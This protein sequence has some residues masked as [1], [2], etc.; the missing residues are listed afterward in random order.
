M[1]S[2]RDG[3]FGRSKKPGKRCIRVPTFSTRGLYRNVHHQSSHQLNCRCQVIAS[4]RAMHADVPGNMYVGMDLRSRQPVVLSPANKVL[5]V[6]NVPQRCRL[7]NEAVF[8]EL[9]FCRPVA[10]QVS[11]EDGV[12]VITKELSFRIRRS[13]LLSGFVIFLSITFGEGCELRTCRDQRTNWRNPIVLLP[14]AQTY[15][16]L[17]VRTCIL[18]DG[19]ITDHGLWTSK[20]GMCWS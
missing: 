15:V 13:G 3:H 16:I 5:F 2:I 7:A 6:Y 17:S 19:C 9:D 11:Y 20:S 8:E 14:K 12:A 10:E 18:I 4:T 1:L